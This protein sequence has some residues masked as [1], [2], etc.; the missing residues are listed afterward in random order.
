MTDDI[1]ARLGKLIRSCLSV[2]LGEC[3]VAACKTSAP[4]A[5]MAV[6]A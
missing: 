2:A 6:G 4:T 3:L 1:T 5:I